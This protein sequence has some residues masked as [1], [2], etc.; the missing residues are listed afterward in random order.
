MRFCFFDKLIAVNRFGDRVT[1]S[2]DHLM[3][4]Y[5]CVSSIHGWHLMKYRLSSRKRR[6]KM[7][8]M[9]DNSN[10]TVEVKEEVHNS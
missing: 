10:T 1:K 7:L 6:C 2:S 4:E 8:Y 9:R 5:E 3:N